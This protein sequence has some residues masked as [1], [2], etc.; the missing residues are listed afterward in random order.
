MQSNETGNVEVH[1]NEIV[2]IVQKHRGTNHHHNSIG[3]KRSYSTS[4]AAQIETHLTA[5]TTNEFKK[6]GKTAYSAKIF[7]YSSVQTF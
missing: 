1:V 3:N 6:A 2:R 5:I 7:V 4:A